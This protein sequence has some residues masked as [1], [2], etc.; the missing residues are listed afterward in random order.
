MNKWVLGIEYDGSAYCGWQKQRHSPSV[1]AELEKALSF[2]A[3]KPV[4]LVCAGRTDTSVHACEQIA[5]FEME[6]QRTDRAWLLGANCRLPRDIRISWIQPISRSFHARFSAIARSYR[7]IIQNSAVPSALFHDK[8][9]WEHRKLDHGLMHNA[10]QKL[11]GEHDFNAFRAAGC[12]AKSAVRTIHYLAVSRS[13]EFIYIDI[14]ANA[15]LHHMVRNIAGS[16]MTIGT[17]EH[18][19][20]W[21][22][23]VLNSKDRRRAAKTAA[24]AG[25]YFIRA[26]YPDEFNLPQIESKPVLF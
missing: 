21:L 8:L 4:E 22:L 25:L 7:Y 24:A 18:D 5:H 1:Q 20:D 12:Q 16:L 15:F 13:D 19:T 9:C 2:V 3:N 11:V 17:G 23:Q 10:A 26:F 14:K 6:I